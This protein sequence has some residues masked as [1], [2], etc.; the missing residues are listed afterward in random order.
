MVR[1]R[2]AIWIDNQEM[3]NSTRALQHYADAICVPL[4][5]DGTTLG[6]MHV[7]LEKGRFRQ[8]DFEV[9]IPLAN[10]LTVALVRARRET[11]LKVEQQRLADKSAVSDEL[12]GGSRPMQELKSKITRVA[13]ATGCV[14]CA[15]KAGWAWCRAGDSRASAVATGR[16]SVNCAA[17]PRDLMESQLFGHSAVHSREPTP[18]MPAS[19][20]RLI[21]ERCSS[22]K[23]AR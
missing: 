13:R 3:E 16:C 1:K 15:A 10:I 9:S 14:L 6:A 7:Y 23:S 2:K 4:V 21:R 11:I 19:S 5:H 18:T 12:L 17:I 20:P 8:V 22:T